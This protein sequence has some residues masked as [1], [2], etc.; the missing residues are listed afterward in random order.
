[1]KTLNPVASTA[2]LALI[3]LMKEEQHLKLN[4]APGSYMPVIIEFLYHT[5]MKDKPM[6]IY[7]LSH[8]YEQNGDLVPDPDMT[9]AVLNALPTHPE[10]L[11]QIYPLT[12]QNAIKYDEA[13]FPE[14]GIWKVYPKLQAD[15]TDFADLWLTNIKH[16]QNL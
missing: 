4:N 5:T 12:F 13:V 10:D 16:Q 8:Y 3:N 2:F 14:E 9:F 1:M 15:L 6:K 11:P 7:S